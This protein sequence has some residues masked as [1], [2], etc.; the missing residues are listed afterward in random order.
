MKDK[1]TI[2]LVFLG[3]DGR[4]FLLRQHLQ[5]FRM[6]RQSLLDDVVHRCRHHRSRHLAAIK[7][8]ICCPV[9]LEDLGG[10]FTVA[11]ELEPFGTRLSH[12]FTTSN[13]STVIHSHP[14]SSTVHHSDRLWICG[15][16]TRHEERWAYWR[17]EMRCWN[18]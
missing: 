12:G 2:R 8:E 14:Q 15:F 1:Q 18:L 5:T 11:K 17:K 13:S 4:Q 9:C 7:E 16:M 3:F 6:E 10:Q